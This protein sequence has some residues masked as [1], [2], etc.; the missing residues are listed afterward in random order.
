MDMNQEELQ[1]RKLLKKSNTIIKE[2]EENKRCVEK[3][4]FE[5]Q[6]VIHHVETDV[7]FNSY[8]EE[9]VLNDLKKQI[10]SDN[11]TSSYLESDTDTNMYS[12][13]KKD[14]EIDRHNKN[15]DNAQ[16]F[17][18]KILQNN[19]IFTLSD[20]T[21]QDEA[22]TPSNFVPKIENSSCVI[23]DDSIQLLPN[24][25][26]TPFKINTNFNKLHQNQI[27]EKLPIIKEEI[28]PYSD[29]TAH[30]KDDDTKTEIFHKDIEIEDSVSQDESNDSKFVLKDNLTITVVNEL[31]ADN[32][33]EQTL[34]PNSHTTAFTTDDE[35]SSN[36][37]TVIKKEEFKTEK[38]SDKIVPDT[39]DTATSCNKPIKYSYLNEN[40]KI[41][42]DYISLSDDELYVEISQEIE[43]NNEELKT[44]DTKRKNINKIDL[45]GN[46][47][48]IL[49]EN[50]IFCR[51][52]ESVNS[53]EIKSNKLTR[54]DT[55]N[56]DFIPDIYP[57]N[58]DSKNV[59]AITNNLISQEKLTENQSNENKIRKIFRN[60]FQYEPII[61]KF[62][63]NLEI[64]INACNSF[65]RELSLFKNPSEDSI[66]DARHLTSVK[67][68]SDE[69]ELNIEN[70]PVFLES[71]KN[72][73]LNKD[74][75][76]I[77][78]K[79]TTE[80][81]SFSENEIFLKD[82]IIEK[83]SIEIR[84]DQMNDRLSD[85][86]FKSAD[87]LDPLDR[88]LIPY[89]NPS[90]EEISEQIIDVDK[91]ITND[92]ENV[93]EFSS[94]H[95]KENT[96][97]NDNST[98]E[99]QKNVSPNNFNQPCCS[100]QLEPEICNEIIDVNSHDLNLKR[101][102]DEIE[103]NVDKKPRQENHYDSLLEYNDEDDAIQ[104]FTKLIFDTQRTVD[105]NDPN[106][107]DLRDLCTAEEFFTQV[108]LQWQSV[109]SLN[110]HTNLTKRCM[111]NKIKYVRQ[112]SGEGKTVALSDYYDIKI[113]HLNDRVRELQQRVKNARK[114]RS[115]ADNCLLGEKI[116]ELKIQIDK[117]DQ[118]KSD[119]LLTNKFYF[120]KNNEWNALYLDERQ[121]KNL[122][123]Q[124][125]VFDK[126][127]EF[128]SK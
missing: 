71:P 128:Y 12:T 32:N 51:K 38:K 35:K 26:S 22:S 46:S 89:I 39:K 19:E 1:I 10:Y 100:K 82:N 8:D 84:N 121:I 47:G 99:I 34:S 86:H 44:K 120:G 96:L 101:K 45:P 94:D 37:I 111:D 4:L 9:T 103:E 72:E 11:S 104:N 74:F 123:E 62:E 77:T 49:R 50:V 63:N 75:E 125:V 59:C 110:P 48:N 56:I 23:L 106:W 109:E 27:N 55:E 16:K 122:D 114:W 42:D 64:T 18:L 66:K 58:N 13:T 70:D 88:T 60:T 20:S 53:N 119:L 115:I 124:D 80:S 107:R 97:S 116:S 68:T 87:S 54:S 41:D 29:V 69:D 52:Q 15:R 98:V 127:R 92:Q 43:G 3:L 93:F 108:S 78:H 61:R 95:N 14:F 25:T 24:F 85:N 21:L 2:M 33:S 17:N 112:M 126:I 40:K 102:L 31:Y 81:E 91:T 117:L 67:S 57:Q 36:N 83:I 65:N 6:D 105:E 79:S 113:K 7:N 76:D 28:N 90:P 73:I 30:A 118:L 5:A